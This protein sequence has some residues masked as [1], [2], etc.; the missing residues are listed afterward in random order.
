MRAYKLYTGKDGRS[1]VTAG[2]VAERQFNKATAIRFQES[3]PHALFDWHTAPATQYVITLSGTLEFT[4]ED[5]SFIIEPGDILIA[6]DT[7]GAGHKW[8]LVDDAPWKRVYVLFEDET[9]IN[10]IPNA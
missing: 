9:D 3:A 10:F 8:Q 4:C 2:T 1:H 5:G 6:T 7:T